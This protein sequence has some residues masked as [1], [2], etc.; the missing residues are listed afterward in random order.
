MASWKAGQLR[1]KGVGIVTYMIVY[2]RTLLLRVRQ[3][4]HLSLKVNVPGVRLFYTCV[5]IYVSY[6]AIE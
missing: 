1:E 2:M 3:Y 5:Y 4:T 6:Y